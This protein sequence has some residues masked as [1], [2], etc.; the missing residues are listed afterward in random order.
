MY[1][2]SA[3]RKVLKDA[4]KGPVFA[5]VG[6][7]EH[8]TVVTMHALWDVPRSQYAELVQPVTLKDAPEPGEAHQS[9]TRAAK[10]WEEWRQLIRGTY[11]NDGPAVITDFVADTAGRDTVMT[12]A[13]RIFATDNGPIAID[14]RFIR[15]I[16]V[17][18][19]GFQRGGGGIVAGNSS[20]RCLL[21]PVS[22][23][24]YGKIMTTAKAICAEYTGKKEG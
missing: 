1:N 9:G 20:I 18:V 4:I 19:A 5:V 17:D 11:G 14:E 21:M 24:A 13:M 10:T 2:K 15:A 22:M 12:P 6:D 23:H 3:F 7:D 8:V 16:D